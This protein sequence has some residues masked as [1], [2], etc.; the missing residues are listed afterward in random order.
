MPAKRFA[1]A[2]I[3]CSTFIACTDQTI[4]PG[5]P[6]GAGGSGNGPPIPGETQVDIERDALGVAHVYGDTKEAAFYGLGWVTAQD[7][8]F[9]MD[10]GRRFMR[11]RMSEVYAAGADNP[12]GLLQHD[13]RMRTLGF[14]RHAERVLGHPDF[15]AEVRALLEAYARG[16]NDYV[17][18]DDFKLPPAF[19]DAGIDT[20][21]PWT[22]VDSL[23]AWERVRERFNSLDMQN[24]I[25]FMNGCRDSSCPVPACTPPIDEAAV[26][27]PETSPWPPSGA[28]ACHE[29]A[30][31]FAQPI[32]FKASHT[33]VVHGSRTTTGKP[34]LAMDPKLGLTAPSMWY[35][36]VIAW[37]GSEARG[38][39]IAGAPGFLVF[40]NRN[41]AQSLTA[42]GG[43]IADLFRL[44]LASDGYLVDG[45]SQAFDSYDET[46]AVEGGAPVAI[47]VRE[48]MFG[49]VVTPLLTDVPQGAEFALRHSELMSESSHSLV[50][51]IE[52]LDAG[53]L[54]SYRTAF[55]KI[56]TP[57][58]NA[59]FA[60]L[61]PENSEGHI[62]YSILGAIGKRAPNLV[63][64]IDWGGR[65]PHD[66]S[67]LANDWKG[68]L[69]IHERPHVIDPEEGYLFSANHRAVGSWFDDY[70]YTGIGGVGDTLRSLRLR[71]LFKELLPTPDAKL[72]PAQ[73]HA[74][75]FDAHHDAVRI[76]R[77]MLAQLQTLGTLPPSAATL[78]QTAPE[79]AAKVLEALDLWL[80]NGGEL[81]SQNP[82]TPVAELVTTHL[83]GVFREFYHPALACKYNGAEGGFSF[84]LKTYDAN[85]DTT[86]ADPDVV[87]FVV[88]ES[89][90]IWDKIG[91][92]GPNPSN[93]P[94][95]PPY[96]FE[97]LYQANQYC[98]STAGGNCSL[99]PAHDFIVPLD[100]AFVHTI[101][102]SLGSSGTGTVDL[103]DVDAST[104][105]VPMGVSEDPTSP[106]FKSGLDEWKATD[107]GDPTGTPM[108]PL[109]RDL[110]ET[111]PD[112]TVTLSYTTTP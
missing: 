20:F 85:P 12:Q 11:G 110:V 50:G 67:T 14:A 99:N 23:L 97:V 27:V 40:W 71:Y 84:M 21:E 41:V 104:H 35:A 83:P 3:A 36:N 70:A 59:V 66:G 30:R 31:P 17:A 33:W 37:P 65:H 107:A 101:L 46:I 52:M 43:D 57:S 61:D 112:E 80:D 42:G 90:A 62:G 10:F 56:L 24:E 47:T 79:K 19:G 88:I 29:T 82:Q 78:P 32:A 63:D 94:A 98:P 16:V 8:L 25:E 102:S 58:A 89:A 38:I 60:A 76:F 51:V 39:G 93:W 106:W 95:K 1:F 34:V 77:D 64:G 22:A 49:P 87:N 5:P 92:A 72:S 81:R 100:G 13:V 103:A 7:R 108:A 111:L 18:G 74:M 4:E 73:V 96:D 28:T 91:H 2:V 9:Q 44:E 109:S 15:P 86:I 48:S 6:Q 69:D 54:D 53:D 26:V 45:Q 75:H 55:G 68:I 105:L